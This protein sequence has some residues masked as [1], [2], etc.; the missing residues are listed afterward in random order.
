MHGAKLKIKIIV[1]VYNN[2]KSFFNHKGII[3]QNLYCH[4]VFHTTPFWKHH[5]KSLFW[6]QKESCQIAIFWYMMLCI[7]TEGYPCLGNTCC[8]AFILLWR[9]QK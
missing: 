2:R 5:V 1:H 3:L 8:S 4:S 9:M 6:I 7:M